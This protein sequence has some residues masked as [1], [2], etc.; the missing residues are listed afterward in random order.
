MSDRIKTDTTAKPQFTASKIKAVAEQSWWKRI[1]K[2]EFAEQFNL[3]E[4][5]VN[6]LRSTPEYQQCVFNLMLGQRSAKSFEKWVR[7]DTNMPQRLG[8][9]MGLDPEMI[10]DMIEQVRQAHDDIAAGKGKV[11]RVVVDPS[12]KK[13]DGEIEMQLRF[14]ESEIGYWARR[15]TE[16]QGEYYQA[17]EQG[18]VELRDKIRERKHLIKAELYQIANWKSPRRAALIYENS[19]GWIKE[20]TAQ[21]FATTDDWEKLITLT[22]LDGIGE[23][24]AS[25]ILHLYDEGQYPILDIHALWSVGLEKKTRDAYPF[26]LEYIAFC[27]DIANRNGIDMRTLDRALWRYSSDNSV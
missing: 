23:P 26:W 11:P 5:Q 18:I 24:T 13:V 16:F 14:C 9:R 6:E 4:A 10:L 27:R 19:E 15:Y 3:T 12:A 20:V 21:A 25:A 1:S 22:R 17:T 2:R 7:A 8:G